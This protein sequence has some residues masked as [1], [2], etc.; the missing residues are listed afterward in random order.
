M[1]VLSTRLT[2]GGIELARKFVELVGQ[3]VSITVHR[4]VDIRVAEMVLNRF[5]VY[6]AADEQRRAG[7]T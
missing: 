7:M 6:A 3:E 4:D 5:R 1:V 2:V